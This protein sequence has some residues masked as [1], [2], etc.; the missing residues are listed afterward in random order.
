MDCRHF[1]E[2]ISPY[3]DQMLDEQDRELFEIHLSK[4]PD[5]KNNLEETRKLISMMKKLNEE[6]LPQGFEDSLFK[7]LE[8]SR[9]SKNLYWLRWIGA[10]AGVL[11]IF[12]SIKAVRNTVLM[13]N[14]DKMTKETPSAQEMAKDEGSTLD[15][16]PKEDLEEE[17]ARSESAVAM[18]DSTEADKDEYSE[19]GQ[20]IT[21]DDGIEATGKESEESYT[22]S[23]RGIQSDI[24]EVYVQDICITPQTLKFMAINNELELVESDEN[25]VVI[26]IMDDEQ[27]NIL[28]DELSKMGEIREVGQETG[29]S[30]VKIIIKNKE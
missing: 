26:E 21:K 18:N 7:K 20:D 4:C 2:C 14:M 25:S 9:E 29:G 10:V 19:V 1:D 24:V 22:G 12:F 11:V 17:T 5:C 23:S 30:K 8:N 3:L 28:F 13:G 15:M 16:A 27:R 6:P